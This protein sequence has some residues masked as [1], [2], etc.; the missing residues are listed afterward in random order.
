AAE[1]APCPRVGPRGLLG[2]FRACHSGSAHFCW[3]SSHGRAWG[4]ACS[5]LS[6]EKSQEFTGRFEGLGSVGI[7]SCVIMTT[8]ILRSMLYRGGKGLNQEEGR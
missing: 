8:E 1:E 5:A 7:A 4:G 2:C 3:Q 6:N